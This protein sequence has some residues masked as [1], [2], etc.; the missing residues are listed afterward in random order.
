[1]VTNQFRQYKYPFETGHIEVGHKRQSNPIKIYYEKYGNGP[2]RALLV[3]GLSAPCQAFSNQAEFL[4]ETGEYTAIIFDNRGNGK[5]DSPY[6]LYTTT[7]LAADALDLLDAFGWHDLVHLVG[8]SLG[9]MISLE[10]ALADPNRF[11]SLTLTSTTAKRILPTW[12]AVS[13]LAKIALFYREP[14]DKLN[15]AMDLVYPNDWLKQIPENPELAK[16]YT[17]NRDKVITS[18]IRHIGQSELQPLH[19]NLGQVSAC[20]RHF[21][22]N[23]RLLKLRKSNINI[24]VVTGTEDNLV[25]PASSFHLND[26]LKPNRFEVFK[27][28]GHNIPEEQTDRY[29]QLLLDHFNT[30]FSNNNNNYGNGSFYFNN[31]AKL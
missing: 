11:L 28:S 22:S 24:M 29:N 27:G 26:I 12:M 17:T 19:G 7:Q 14:K 23:D 1:M 15:A 30:S 8:I 16:K 20:L 6:G 2:K 13:T 21:V 3:M 31:D 25:P 4:A 9:G 10:M 5:S 18:F